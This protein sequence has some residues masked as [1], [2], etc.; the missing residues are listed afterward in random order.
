MESDKTSH[1]GSN[2]DILTYSHGLHQLINE[3][4]RLPDPS[5]SCIDL[6]FTSLPNLAMECGF[7][8]SLH[9]N[10]YYQ[11][12]MVKFDLS[13]NYLPPYEKQYDTT[14]EGTLILSGG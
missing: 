13:I 4:I 1:E 10:C 6:T 14:K 5:S 9:P 7:Q 12:V 8:P 3:P 2:L 11:L